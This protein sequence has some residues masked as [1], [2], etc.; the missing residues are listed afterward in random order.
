MPKAKEGTTTATAKAPRKRAT[1]KAPTSEQIQQRAYEIYLERE[2][3]PGDPLSDWIQAERE[4]TARKATRI[5][6][7]KAKLEASAAA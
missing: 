7:P 5:A 6:K 2:G 3:A 4:L 1:K